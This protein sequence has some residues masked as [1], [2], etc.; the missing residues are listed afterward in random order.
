MPNKDL[1][2]K[3][4]DIYQDAIELSGKEQ[5]NF[6]QKHVSD[7]HTLELA[8]YEILESAELAS[9]QAF[10][11]TPAANIKQM[12]LA[13]EKKSIDKPVP[14]P[15]PIG[16]Y[17]PIRLIGEGG[18]G[19]VF[20]AEQ[21]RPVTR[22][23]AIKLIRNELF[24]Q[25]FI[26][27]F[28]TERQMLAVLNHPNI[29]NIF[30]AGTTQ[31]NRPYLVMEYIR[32]DNLTDYCRKKKLGIRA[33]LNLFLRVCYAIQHAHQKGVIHRDIKPANIL[34]LEQDEIAVP[35]VID[36]GIAKAL[37]FEI[38]EKTIATCV[39]V[40]GSPTYMS[41]EQVAQKE[42]DID[43]RSDVY[44]LG[45]LLYELLVG[46][47]PFV[48]DD[49]L[50]TLMNQIVSQEPPRPSVKASLLVNEQIRHIQHLNPSSLVK[51]LNGDLD[52]IIL[53]ALEKSRD[54][55]YVSASAFAA[56]INR[57]LNNEPVLARAPTK[58]YRI[59]KFVHRHTIGV[60]S[61]IAILITLVAGII[62]TTDG[63][64]NAKNESAK[65]KLA[66]TDAKQQTETAQQTVRL[67][68]EFL[69]AVDPGSKG[70]ELKVIDLLEAFKP[71][72]EQLNQQPK[73]QTS[74]MNTY[75]KTYYGLGIFPEAKQFNQRAIEISET[76][77]G[78][79]HPVVLSQLIFKVNILR[80]L[81]EYENAEKW[82][83]Q[84]IQQ[85]STSLGNEHPL[86]LDATSVTADVLKELGKFADAEELHRETLGKRQRILGDEHLDTVYSKARLAVA[87]GFQ[88]KLVEAIR[89][90]R[91]VLRSRTRL[92]GA[93][94]PLTLNTMNNLAFAIGESGGLKESENLH[95]A[96]YE[97]RLPVLGADHPDTLNSLSNLAWTLDTQ[98]KYQEAEK[99]TRLVWLSEKRVLGEEHPKTLL[100][101]GNLAKS[102]RHLGQLKE[103]E[104]IHREVWQERQRIIGEDH[105]S[106]LS[107]MNDLAVTLVV[108][109]QYQQA[110]TL[111]QNL[112]KLRINS[113]GKEH[114]RTF[115][116]MD[117]LAIVF[118][119]LGEF[120][121]AIK[122]SNATLTT[123]IN[124]LGENHRSTLNSQHN[125][126]NILMEQGAFEEAE[127]IYLKTLAQRKK[128]LGDT[129]S[130]T[131]QSIIALGIISQKSGNS[132]RAETLYQEA[133]AIQV[134]KNGLA[135]KLPQYTR[136]L[137][138]EL[139]NQE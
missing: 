116:S 9:K 70:K 128:I 89:L 32:G 97:K 99:I 81:G 28:E 66:E 95:R 38:N 17:K 101:L 36:F 27:R 43:T 78:A 46:S 24:D 72:L 29:A 2:Q 105:P 119:K 62:G 39:D 120:G 86:T 8:V 126:A 74:L 49:S 103:A 47:P 136:R 124:S 102:M 108:R 21:T 68:L 130:K 64:Y 131:V 58:A 54:N 135:H 1:E 6:I 118:S 10:M 104:A 56:D 96:T 50:I 22:K 80:K 57:F 53:K 75:A 134:E 14:I 15:P 123:K 16:N 20:L 18:F 115:D 79:S 23:V 25:K 93:E 83:R 109:Q 106:T 51:K 37:D 98:G 112:I 77:F 90:N 91:E 52:W 73:I 71:K 65:A 41:P 137:L 19:Q 76:A 69:S 113:Q 7:N 60:I 110:K 67:L 111:Y 133:L 127:Q 63:Y 12:G 114:A 5:S 34:V 85:S 138:D 55:R 129:H 100:S 82:G 26:T 11:N 31:D 94:H 4:F 132:E 30:D 92:L 3:A 35:K 84:A 121:R 125:L 59:N 87:L 139:S 45:I 61:S 88:N 40:F 44:S 107:A 42:M 122:L 117:K 13:D 48:K 33:R